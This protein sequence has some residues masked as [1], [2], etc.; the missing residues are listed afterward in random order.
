MADTSQLRMLLNGLGMVLA[1]AL[2]AG[3]VRADAG[4]VNV[5]YAG[6]LVDLMERHVG[7]AFERASG[8]RVDG[9]AGGSTQLA[10]EIKGG[11]RIADVFISAS[12]S[13]DDRLMGP[14]NG[15]LVR[16]YVRFASSPLLIAYNPKSRFA[17]DFR[18]RRWDLVLQEP[19]L[20]LGRTDPKL[21]PKGALTVELMERAAAAYHVP[22]LVARTLGWT[23]N[24]DQVFPEEALIGRLQ[25]GQLDAGFFYATEAA[26]MRLET[27]RL[28]PDMAPEAVYTLAIPTN[29]VDAPGAARFAAFLLGAR[30]RPLLAAGGLDVTRPTLV[31]DAGDAP[32]QIRALVAPAGR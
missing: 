23:E 29:A 10:N 7:P 24:P 20:R 17:A 12:P 21:D 32:A 18:R 28:P 2:T 30:A 4:T 22:D 13:A 27:I 16:S 26:A 1:T 25:S 5:L 3:V 19:G 15:D 14:G 6:S 9:Y 11:L 31:G 8:D